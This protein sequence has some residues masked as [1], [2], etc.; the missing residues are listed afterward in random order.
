MSDDHHLLIIRQPRPLLDRPHAQLDLHIASSYKA[1]P[2]ILQRCLSAWLRLWGQH[3]LRSSL[4]VRETWRPW[5]VENSILVPNQRTLNV[6]MLFPFV[7]NIVGGK[8]VTLMPIVGHGLDISWW[9]VKDC[10]QDQVRIMLRLSTGPKT[11]KNRTKLANIQQYPTCLVGFSK[12]VTG[13]EWVCVWKTDDS[14]SHLVLIAMKK[15]ILRSSASQ[16]IVSQ[17]VKEPEIL[18]Q[19][20][21][22][23]PHCV[24]EMI[25]P[26]ICVCYKSYYQIKY[27]VGEGPFKYKGWKFDQKVVTPSIWIKRPDT[28]LNKMGPWPLYSYK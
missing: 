15:E 1:L 28:D 27:V 10:G 25:P 14:F 24:G 22:L 23:R 19:I 26:W 2:S 16:L 7:G 9:S 6:L 20:A 5:R 8:S 3:L 18:S 11:H 4:S 21:H 17:S 13:L 12:G